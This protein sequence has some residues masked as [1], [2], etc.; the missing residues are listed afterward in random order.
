MWLFC[1]PTASLIFPI[2]DPHAGLRHQ[3]RTDRRDVFF[4]KSFRG[5]WCRER[6]I[7][8][9]LMFSNTLLLSACGVSRTVIPAIGDHFLE[10]KLKVSSCRMEGIFFVWRRVYA[11][12]NATLLWWGVW[13]LRLNIHYSVI[14]RKSHPRRLLPN[15]APCWKH[16]KHPKETGLSRRLD[17]PE[18]KRMFD[19]WSLLTMYCCQWCCRLLGTRADVRLS[20]LG[21]KGRRESYLITILILRI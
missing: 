21:F 14:Q 19:P 9:R 8:E 17:V 5:D 12:K 16:E 7:A 1:P 18:E 10:R 11:S 3:L 4:K 15:G 13:D 20:T 6:A 2:L